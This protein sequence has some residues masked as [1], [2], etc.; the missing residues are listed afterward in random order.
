VSSIQIVLQ[1]S[2]AN[3]HDKLAITKQKLQSTDVYHAHVA[4]DVGVPKI[5]TVSTL[6]E[7]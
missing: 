3:A 7:K 5:I 6:K 2:F 4:C 1:F